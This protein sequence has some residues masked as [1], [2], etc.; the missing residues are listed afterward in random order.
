MRD[1][2]NALYIKLGMGGCWES[3]SIMNGRIRIGW[4]SIPL[5]LIKNSHWDKI[6]EII[7]DDFNDKKTGSTND[8]NALRKIIDADSNTVFMTFYAGKMYW[9]TAKK[10]SINEDEISKFL[11]T[12]KPWSCENILANRVFEMNQ[13]SGRLTKY[14]MFLGTCCSIGNKLNEFDYLKKIINGDESEEYKELVLAKET[15]KRALIPAIRNLIPK[16]FEILIDLIF[17]NFGWKRTSVLGEVMKFFD[18]VLEEPLTKKLHGV[19]I[20]SKANYKIYKEYKE[21]FDENYKS[22]FTSFFFVVHTSDKNLENITS[23]DNI[24][25]LNAPDIADYAIDSGLITWV[26][27][28][29]L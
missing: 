24:I 1:I 9:C 2:K 4:K 6:K 11:V 3:D 25:I 28:K 21:K 13:I 14:Q 19:Q 26:M 29:S 12:E 18:L 7:I 27:N 23:E 20:K 15:L 16:D 10:G 8:F 22:D 5:N 17:R